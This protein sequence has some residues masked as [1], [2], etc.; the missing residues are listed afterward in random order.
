MKTVVSALTLV[1]IYCR[2]IRKRTEGSA[3]AKG[4]CLDSTG[5]KKKKKKITRT[6]STWAPEAHGTPLTP[7]GMSTQD[8]CQ[9]RGMHTPQTDSSTWAD[10]LECS[11]FG[12]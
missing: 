1:E 10:S 12:E 5:P 3:C 8:T 9:E 2:S 11:P 6:R 4:W 7:L